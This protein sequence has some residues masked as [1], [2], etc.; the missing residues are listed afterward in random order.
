MTND[1]YRPTPEAPDDAAFYRGQAEQAQRFYF[2]TL[3]ALV[4]GVIANGFVHDSTLDRLER[5]QAKIRSSR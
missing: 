3:V 1:P 2:W 5:C 4:L